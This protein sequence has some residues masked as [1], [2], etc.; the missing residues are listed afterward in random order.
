MPALDH[1]ERYAHPTMQQAV[2]DYTVAELLFA[3]TCG[4]I[5]GGNPPYDV[6]LSKC[7]QAPKKH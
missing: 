4:R 5:Y 2:A 6:A 7:Q 3:S 1:P